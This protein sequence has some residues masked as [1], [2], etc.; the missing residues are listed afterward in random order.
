MFS[1]INQKDNILIFSHQRIAKFFAVTAPALLVISCGG[2]SDTGTTSTGATTAAATSQIA[3]ASGNPMATTTAALTVSNRAR[4]S[5]P[6]P[7]PM[8]GVTIDNIG[9]LSAILTSL[10]S[11]SIVPTTRI[12][13]DEF[14]PATY[15]K[16][17][18]TKIRDASY[19]MGE[20][21]DS[22]YVR[23]YSVQSY[24]DRTKEYV[25][26]LGDSVDI[27]EIGNEINGEWLGTTPDVVAKMTGAYD[28]VKSQGK[29]AELTLYY[30]KDCWSNPSNEMFT[31]AQ[32]N[33]PDRMKQGLDYVLVSFYEDDCNGIKPD[34]PQV[35]NQLQSMFPNAKL[36]FG[37][38]GT[39]DKTKKA[40]YITRYYTKQISNPNYVGGYFWWYFYQDMVPNTQPLLE[41]LNQAVIK[42]SSSTSTS[43]PTTTTTSS[44]TTTTTTSPTTTT[45]S[46]T[47]TATAPTTTTT[48]TIATSP[49]TSTTDT[50]TTTTPPLT[51]GYWTTIYNGYGSVSYDA[52]AGVVL[53]PKAPTMPSETHA[54][55]TLANNLQ[56]RNFR[57]NITATVEQQTRLNSAPNPWE[58]FW[59]FFNYQPTSAGKSTNYFLLK[60]NGVELG[61]A[62]DQVGQTF[63]QTG[64]ADV[65]AI[66]VS[67]KY[68]IEKI[69]NRV[70]V[71]LNGKVVTNFTGAIKDVAGSIGLYAE[72]ARV[73]VT[74]VQVT[75]LL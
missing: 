48:T 46:P 34:W 16:D 11:I 64:P 57:L 30:N 47:T 59:I 51:S 55:L 17:A 52:T 2:S 58:T 26:A 19:V 49:T 50:S 60:P 12:V 28:I 3:A 75:P 33:V 43:S 4:P 71:S 35:F 23:Q 67:N 21:L 22:Y 74:N 1:I 32:K 38:V 36:G 6:I 31:W 24:L 41:T 20:L 42:A 7:S 5:L 53:N 13:F 18:T 29:T 63:L 54:A 45:S 56:L 68:E 66:G 65:R 27:W 39:I 72:D 62:V 37:E 10:K 25:N 69:G 8:V 9:N 44:P 14:M 15:Y 73:R 61:T 70:T 40:E